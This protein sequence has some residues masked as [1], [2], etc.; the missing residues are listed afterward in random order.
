[1]EKK[2][3]FRNKWLENVHNHDIY[4]F[5]FVLNTDWILQG[6]VWMCAM[7]L[8]ATDFRAEDITSFFLEFF[9][10]FFFHFCF[11]FSI[12]F[13]FLLVVEHTRFIMPSNCHPS[14]CQLFFFFFPSVF[15]FFFS[16]WGFCCC[17]CLKLL[18]FV[19]I[20]G[21]DVHRWHRWGVHLVQVFQRL[22]QKVL[23]GGEC[24]HDGWTAESVS[25][26]RKVR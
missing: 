20:F 7:M 21:L 10:P 14:Y 25:D 4:H 12:D 19:Q 13:L 1:M 23:N 17:C 6:N 26:E 8:H 5:L 2:N 11:F 15:F 24:S 9:F 22:V 18:F 16:C 3:K